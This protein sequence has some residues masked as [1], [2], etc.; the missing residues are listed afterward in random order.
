MDIAYINFING[1]PVKYGS[2]M[3]GRISTLGKRR[4]IAKS[5]KNWMKQHWQYFQ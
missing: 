3:S 2:I 1:Y 4:A 5:V